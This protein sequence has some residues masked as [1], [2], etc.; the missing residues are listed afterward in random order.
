MLKLMQEISDAMRMIISL[1]MFF[2]LGDGNIILW[3]S[4]VTLE[5]EESLNTLAK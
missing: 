1:I 5:R 3:I 2:L 4:F